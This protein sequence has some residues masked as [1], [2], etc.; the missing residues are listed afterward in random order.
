M[1]RR[2]SLSSAVASAIFRFRFAAQRVSENGDAAQHQRNAQQHAHGES[3]PEEAELNVGLAKQFGSDAR[4]AI[5]KR[6]TSGDDAGPLERAEAHHEA[7][8]GEEHDAFQ[9]R[10][11]ELA[12]MARQR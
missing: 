8:Y 2:I 4:H 11:I 5:A 6:K 9:R 3:A 1:R 12:R 7:E 10:F